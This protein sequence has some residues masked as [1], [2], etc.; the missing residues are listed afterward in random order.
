MKSFFNVAP[1]LPPP[2]YASLMT[3]P[4][5]AGLAWAGSAVAVR[6]VTAT[7]RPRAAASPCRD[8]GLGEGM[9]GPSES[10]VVGGESEEARCRGPSGESDAR[11]PNPDDA[12]STRLPR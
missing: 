3:R 6:P 5:P 12:G 9:G 10:A 4:V 11:H 2:P 8:E 1:E 7:P